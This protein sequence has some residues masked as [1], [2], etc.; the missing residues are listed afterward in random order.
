MVLLEKQEQS[1]AAKISGLITK[2]K[3]EAE[4]QKGGKRNR[5]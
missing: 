3:S 4:I 5:G 2:L 1:F